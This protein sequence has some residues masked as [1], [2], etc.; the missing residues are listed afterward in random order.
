MTR[1]RFLKSHPYFA[2]DL[3]VSHY[4]AP[5]GECVV[6]HCFDGL[7]FRLRFLHRARS[8]PSRL[9]LVLWL[10]CL[11]PRVTLLSPTE[12]YLVSSVSLDTTCFGISLPRPPIFSPKTQPVR[13]GS[14]YKV[15]LPSGKQRSRMVKS[16]EG[17]VDGRAA[18]WPGHGKGHGMSVTEGGL[19]GLDLCRGNPSD[20]NYARHRALKRFPVEART[21]E[22]AR[23]SE[24]GY[25]LDAS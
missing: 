10:C 11:L 15:H 4:M 5:C 25:D 12:R 19:R 17:S 14:Q 22:F 3:A 16:T 18:V 13:R 7:S 20:T 9:F 24:P 2:G 8:V 6:M 1:G 21:W 23:S